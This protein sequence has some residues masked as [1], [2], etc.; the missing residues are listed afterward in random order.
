[1]R[2]AA[3][4]QQGANSLPAVET[5]SAAAN[6]T[7]GAGAAGSG[8][9]RGD[10]PAARLLPTGTA[11]SSPQEAAPASD[12]L[13]VAALARA[14]ARPVPNGAMVDDEGTAAILASGRRGLGSTAK[15]RRVGGASSPL[16]RDGEQA[17]GVGRASSSGPAAEKG[18]AGGSG[19]GE[20]GAG[21]SAPAAALGRDG[22]SGVREVTL[23]ALD[24]G[25]IAGAS[26]RSSSKDEGASGAGRGGA[27]PEAFAWRGMPTPWGNFMTPGDAVLDAAPTGR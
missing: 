8:A 21:G 27:G 7:A 26:Q 17:A 6:V 11:A 5:S 4:S 16:A 13:G 25:G 15:P 9:A 22:S 23:H 20:S 24:R 3:A 12:V 10:G 2:A 14:S 19:P 18:R 1:M